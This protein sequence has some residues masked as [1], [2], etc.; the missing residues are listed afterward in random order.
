MFL[1]WLL[2]G[3]AK[4]VESQH[5][6]RNLFC[7]SRLWKENFNLVQIHIYIYIYIYSRLLIYF[8]TTYSEEVT[9]MT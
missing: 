2:P 9:L 8:A 1:V 4:M 7:K 3:A 6:D 5:R